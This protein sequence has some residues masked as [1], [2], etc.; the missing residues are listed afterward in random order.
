MIFVLEYAM[1]IMSQQYKDNSIM[2]LFKVKASIL[3][4]N[5]NDDK[6][7]HVH[8]RR[9]ACLIIKIRSKIEKKIYFTRV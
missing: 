9:A 8:A 7:V 5:P 1:S 3:P 2:S 4:S 6:N